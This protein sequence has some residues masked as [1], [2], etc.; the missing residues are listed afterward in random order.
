MII[1]SAC[2]TG[3]NCTYKGRNNLNKRLKKMAEE[4]RAVSLCP[5]ELGGLKTPRPRAEILGRSGEDVFSGKARVITES[6]RDV[7]RNYIAGAKAALKKAREH[8]VKVAVLKSNSPSCGLGHI[9]DG[10]FGKSV[11]R[12]NGVCA[13]LFLDKGIYVMTEKDL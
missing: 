5:E 7:T 10:T 11:K 4:R 2:L 1:V 12:G 6:G 9:Y 8:R 13:Q 3:A